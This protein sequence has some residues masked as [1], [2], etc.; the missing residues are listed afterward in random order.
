MD[1]WSGVE[2]APPW[3][4]KWTML[5]SFVPSFV[6]VHAVAAEMTARDAEQ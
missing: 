5:R 1:G 2:I 6:H 3:T 4:F